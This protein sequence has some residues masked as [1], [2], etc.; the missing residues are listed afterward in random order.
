MCDTTRRNISWSKKKS[1]AI[2]KR[3][4]R[5]RLRLYMDRFNGQ[6]VMWPSPRGKE[7][8]NRRP[9]IPARTSKKQGLNQ[10]RATTSGLSGHEGK[11]T[12]SLHT[13]PP[14]ASTSRAEKKAKRGCFKPPSAMKKNHK[15]VDPSPRSQKRPTCVIPITRRRK[16]KPRRT[17][18]SAFDDTTLDE[19]GGS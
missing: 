12:S 1:Q 16:K 18:P 14:T 7:N 19:R 15:R 10:T 3:K 2:T 9:T 4:E 17:A 13:H 6:T 11:K 8:A 5:K